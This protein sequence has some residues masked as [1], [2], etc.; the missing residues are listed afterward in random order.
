MSFL[1]KDKQQNSEK[2][3][4]E[5][6]LKA[7]GKLIVDI[8]ETDKDLVIEA[9]IAGVSS[10]DIEISLEKDLLIIKGKREKGDDKEKRKYLLQ[11]CYWGPFSREIIL[12]VEV[13]S[14]KA[15]AEVNNGMLTIKIP[16]VKKPKNGKIKITTRKKKKNNKSEE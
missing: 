11:E 6:W 13:N 1:S 4:K 12:P 10:D 8:Y 9:P 2:E 15:E 7:E 5:D 3:K 14:A 16:K